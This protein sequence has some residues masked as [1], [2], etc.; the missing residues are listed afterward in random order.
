MSAPMGITA[1]SLTKWRRARESPPAEETPNPA[2]R[3]RPETIPAEARQRLRDCY[4]AHHRQWG[5]RVLACW[6]RREALG[7]WSPT[8]IARILADLVEPPEAEPKPTRYEVTASGAMWS[9]DGAGFRECGQKKELLVAQDEHSRFKVNSRLV[10][11]PARHED[12][13][14]YLREAFERHGAP[15]VLKHDGGA[16][17]HTPRLQ[18]LLADYGVIE[19]TSPPY[20]PRYNGKKERSV[21][22]LKSYERALRRDR[23]GGSLAERIANTIHDLN[24]ERPRPVLGGRTAGEVFHQD[25]RGLPTREQFHQEVNRTETRLREEATTRRQQDHARRRAVEEVLLRHRLL[26]IRADVSTDF[27][28][29]I[30]TD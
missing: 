4:L 27:H 6:A 3:G 16:I 29:E 9:E 18:A 21:R 20:W 7:S 17:F 8:T 23:V 30:R 15:L 19:L 2:R 13:H 12:V 10:E 24:E 26:E 14:D 1:Q 11:G 5:P 22:D 25:R 28:A